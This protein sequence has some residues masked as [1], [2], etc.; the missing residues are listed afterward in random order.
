M[1]SLN[2]NYAPTQDYGSD[3]LGYFK[4]YREQ[5]EF[6]K[7]PVV[8]DEEL[9]STLLASEKIEPEQL[10]KTAYSTYLAVMDWNVSC[11]HSEVLTKRPAYKTGAKAGEPRSDLRRKFDSIRASDPAGAI[12]FWAVW[13]DGRWDGVNGGA[14]VIDPTAGSWQDD[15]GAW[16]V[17][18]GKRVIS[19][20][21]DFNTWLEVVTR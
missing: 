1:S 3:W 4:D 8:G 2:F 13:V 15:E 11:V 5:L 14:V 16:H 6:A 21:G 7:L 20:A 12:G 10:P 19:L 17:A 9:G 18:P